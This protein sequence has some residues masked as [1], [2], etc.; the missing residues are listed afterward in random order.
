VLGAALGNL[1]RGVP[2]DSTGYFAGP[3]FTNFQPGAHAGVLDWFTVLVGVLTLLILAEHGA[4]YLAFKTTGDV[5]KRCKAIARGLW[6]ALIVVGLLATVAVAKVQP[7]IVD[8]VQDRWWIWPLIAVVFAGVGAVM[9]L[10]TKGKELGAFLAS[11]ITIAIMLASAVLAAY[12]NILISTLNPAW[13]LTVHNSAAGASTLKIGLFWW[14]LALAIA[15]FYFA[16]LFRSF[17][18]KVDAATDQ[19]GH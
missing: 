3:L 1:I 10:H 13:S 4:L 6:P 14:P 19:Y 16:T 11:S 2:I 5:N 15:I 18:G 12:P 9:V 8:N 7:M 17:K